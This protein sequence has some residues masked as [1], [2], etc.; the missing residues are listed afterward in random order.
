MKK[1]NKG[2]SFIESMQISF[3]EEFPNK[4]NLEKL[5]L[6]KFPTKL[7]LADYSIDGYKQYEKELRKK[8][9][10]L[11]E[12]IWWPVINV[13]DGYWLSPWTRR[14]ALLK[15]LNQLNEKKVPIMWDAEFPKNRKLIFTEF[16]KHFKNK[17]II[18]SFFRKYEG[19]IYTAEYF[20]ENKLWKNFLERTCLSFDPKNYNN[21]VIKMVY[22][23][24]MPWVSEN[25]IRNEIKDYIK[26]Y[27]NK[28]IVGLGVIAVGINGNENLITAEDL[29]RDLRI[30]KES[31]VNEVVIY[32][33]GG[34][35]KKYLKIINKFTR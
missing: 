26:N 23:S 17:K 11:K 25:F 2:G 5:K 29:E 18:K 13:H 10:N 22:S 24:M 8:Y 9:R 12:A 33:L 15:A 30:C 16:F 6:I 31:N 32:R 20:A 35:N 21:A 19:R 28:F 34:L 14:R 7:Y 1:F 27:G 3:F 4:K